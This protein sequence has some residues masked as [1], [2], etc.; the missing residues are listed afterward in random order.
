MKKSTKRN[1]SQFVMKPVALIL[2]CLTV[3]AACKKDENA[4]ATP[5]AP[6][7]TQLLT[8][9]PWTLTASTVS[10]AMMG[11][12]NMYSM[13]SACETDNT[14]KF[15]SDASKTL[16]QDEGATK[17]TTTDPQSISGSWNMNSGETQ[18]TTML[19]GSSDT[20]TLI[21]LT[22]STLSASYTMDYMGV[23]YTIVNT[24]SN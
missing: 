11:M 3:F 2:L 17:C 8:S 1:V 14:L 4:P 19:N 7:R 21:Q 24:Y 12:T 20:Y 10:P 18:V 16:V 9:K 5:V 23:T 22:S 6:T 13:M 15:N